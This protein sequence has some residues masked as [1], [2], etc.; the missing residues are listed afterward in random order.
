MSEAT[1]LNEKI[2]GKND[3]P[4]AEDA[5][6]LIPDGE[7]QKVVEKPLPPETRREP[8][9]KRLFKRRSNVFFKLIHDQA[10]LTFDGL[11]ALVAY[12]NGQSP[13]AAKRLTRAEKDADEARRI[14]IY[15]LNRT[16][17]TPI[18]REDIFEISRSIDDVLDYAYS[19]MTEMEV[20]RVKPTTFMERMASLLRE[21]AFELFRRSTGWKNTPG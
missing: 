16:Y 14:L 4:K 20:L 15:E 18:D 13:E 19:T 7:V 9:L 2:K 3:K 1:K 17:I 8:F 10:A 5:A 12:M 6:S 21:A 11:D